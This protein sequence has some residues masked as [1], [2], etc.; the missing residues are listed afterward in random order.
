MKIVSALTLLKRPMIYQRYVFFILLDIL[1]LFNFLNG[2]FGLKPVIC[3]LIGV[4]EYF[5]FHDMV[6]AVIV[7]RSS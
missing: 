4:G 5:S 7:H 3:F 6:A 2:M 1:G